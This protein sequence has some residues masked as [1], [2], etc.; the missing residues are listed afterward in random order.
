M[1]FSKSFGNFKHRSLKDS[2]FKKLW[3][4]YNDK[5]EK[6][7]DCQFRYQC[8]SNSDIKEEN[9]KYYKVDTCDYDP[10]QNI[11]NAKDE[12]LSET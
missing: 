6:C 5:I 11:W 1:A 4:I 2:N 3:Y 8:V 7:K 10:Y 12:V 9:G